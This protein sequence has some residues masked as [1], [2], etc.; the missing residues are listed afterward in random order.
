MSSFSE[1]K[2]FS[3][4][5]TGTKP[6]SAGKENLGLSFSD[7]FEFRWPTLSLYVN[8]YLSFCKEPLYLINNGVT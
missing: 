2:P 5:L 3:L 8:I 7:V 1:E 4:L 6:C